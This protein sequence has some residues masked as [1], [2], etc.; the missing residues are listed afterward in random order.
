MMQFNI[1]S[2][3]LGLVAIASLAG[4]IFLT[5]S[6]D[7]PT[8]AWTS[9]TGAIGLLAGQQMKTPGES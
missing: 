2:L 7:D 1:V 3:M 9:T 5:W 6:G 4:A 8:A